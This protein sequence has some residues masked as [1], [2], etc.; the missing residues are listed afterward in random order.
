MPRLDPQIREMV[1]TLRRRLADAAVEWALTGSASFVLQGV[2]LEPDDVDVQT[3]KAGACAIEECFSDDVVEPVS[4]AESPTIR[5]HFGAVD[6][7]GVRV[8]VMG[9]LQKRVDG[10]WE[11]PVDVTEHRK[12]V[13]LGPDR[14]PV[15]SLEYEARAYEKL[16]RTDRAALLRTY[17]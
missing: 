7:N 14:I 16:G 12:Y 3:T 11:P 2:P 17:A 5:S 1:L 10:G 13:S 15:L 8:E 9:D 6:V 4:F